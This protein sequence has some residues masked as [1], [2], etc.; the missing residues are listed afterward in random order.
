M[1]Q[2]VF[3]MGHAGPGIREK[4]AL[5][6]QEYQRGCGEAGDTLGVLSDFLYFYLQCGEGSFGVQ[7][8]PHED[9]SR[10]PTPLEM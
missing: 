10:S 1:A 5:L 7:P 4:P 2:P 6:S 8:L 9:L 3:G